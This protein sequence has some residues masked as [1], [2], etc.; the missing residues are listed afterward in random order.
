LERLKPVRE[1]SYLKRGFLNGRVL[2]VEGE[3]GFHDFGGFP[4]SRCVSFS[5]VATIVPL[6]LACWGFS[7]HLDKIWEK[8]H[9]H[10][11]VYI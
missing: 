5:L 11:M 8:S 10:G 6:G 7:L 4:S 9:T 2:P 1:G 3:E